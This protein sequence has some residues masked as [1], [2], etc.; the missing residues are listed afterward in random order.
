MSVLE[1]WGKVA[2]EEAGP[3]DAI[4][5]VQPR[6]VVRPTTTEE[7]STVLATAH[8]HG[9]AVV[10]RGAGTTLAWG[11][12]P[13]RVDVILDTTALAGVIDHVAGDLMV[14]VRAGTRLA[15]LQW[16]LSTAGQRL[17]LDG[18]EHDAAS[19]GGLVAHGLSG[20][21]RLGYGTLR[22]QLIGATFVRADGVVAHTGGRVVKNVAG[23]DLGKVLHGSW[24][25]LAVLTEAV[26]KLHPVP[27]ARRWITMAG[28]L[29]A[30]VGELTQRVV[31]TQLVPAAL[32]IDRP[33]GGPATLAVQ[34]DGR[35]ATVAAR[36]DALA[37]LLGPTGQPTVSDA[38]PSWWGWRPTSSPQG[39]RDAPPHTAAN[40][41]ENAD[42][43]ASQGPCD[44]PRPAAPNRAENA[45]VLLRITT[46]VASLP[47]LLR[48]TDQASAAIGRGVHL[49]GSAG[50]G[51][52]LA[53]V[54]S[55]GAGPDEIG[56]LADLVGRLR[57]GA[58]A[59]GGTVV[60]LDGP[61]EL[62]RSADVWG[63]IPAL[64][65]MRR[66]KE[67]FDPDRL[68]SPGRFVGGI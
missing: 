9:L 33:A 64:D 45:G 41:A 27:Q 19:V 10:P 18:H 39:P 4:R 66:L 60:L 42:L 31:H 12:P 49:R 47:D 54:S 57:E 40:R 1:Q 36:A 17:T 46:E 25:T 37:A 24:G 21:S 29:P 30:E 14:A 34:L 53:A 16:A 20:P 44:T 28:L 61:T 3:A 63:P 50:K 43:P 58:A 38:A 32:E 8:T 5:G 48:A 56:L 35:A 22:D 2:V 55:A 6:F 15:D 52:L 23:Y 67:Q 59:C 7:V 65:L 11:P 13:E 26:F 62:L 51:S 68:L